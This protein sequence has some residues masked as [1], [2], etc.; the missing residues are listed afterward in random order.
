MWISDSE[1]PMKNE[2]PQTATAHA[3]G[4]SRLEQPLRSAGE[5]IICK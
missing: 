5:N 1:V 3:L 2:P 4:Y